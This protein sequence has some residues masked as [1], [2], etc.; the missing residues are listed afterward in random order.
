MN[1]NRT[2]VIART[3][4]STNKFDSL[5][6]VENGLLLK[7]QNKREIKIPYTELDKIYIKK[8]KLN[9]F[10]EFLC[11]AF[12]F[13]FVYIAMQYLPFYLM[14]LVSVIT[15]LPVFIR[16]INYKWY[17]LFVFL[18]DGTFFTKR[19]SLHK[20]TENFSI[21][22]RVEKEIFDYKSSILTSA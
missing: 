5:K 14:I 3:I 2:S 6:V 20:K 18:N 4:T 15:V 19:V 9:P 11:I 21:L 17:K 16:V 13:L 7:C 8:C 12:P 22:N 1:I 10:V